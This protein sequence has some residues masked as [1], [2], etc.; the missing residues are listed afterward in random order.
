MKTKIKALVKW[1]C[2]LITTLIIGG[3]IYAS[4]EIFKLYLGGSFLATLYVANLGV[5]VCLLIGGGLWF[6]YKWSTSD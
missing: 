2:I 3:F 1:F 6:A 4:I 5:G